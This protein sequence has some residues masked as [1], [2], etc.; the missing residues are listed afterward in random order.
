[1]PSALVIS[2][3]CA[4]G[5]F[6]SSVAVADDT[7]DGAKKTL[8]VEEILARDPEQSDYRDEPRCLQ[9][10]RI[11]RMEVIDDKHVSMQVSR[12]RFYLVQ[13]DHRCPGLRRGRPVMYE[14]N[15][16][17]RL[18]QMDRIRGVY[19]NGSGGFTP[20]VPCAINGFQSVTKEQLVMLKDALK[21]ERRKK[22]DS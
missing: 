20:G 15:S 8:S 17:N 7:T 10:H 16:G 9:T 22:K 18:C 5:L 13:L 3:L 14:P 4:W 6:A 2:L 1:V 19:E 21:V 12:D 11:R